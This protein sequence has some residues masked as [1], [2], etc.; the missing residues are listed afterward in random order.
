MSLA[1]KAP[2]SSLTEAC[3]DPILAEDKRKEDQ[4]I[5]TIKEKI[6]AEQLYLQPKLTL[7]ELSRHLN[8]N[9]TYLSA[10]INHQTG[11]NFNAFVNDFRLKHIASYA[12]NNPRTSAEKLAEMSGF[13]SV[14]SMHR[15]M[16][17][18]ELNQNDA[19]I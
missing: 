18:Q 2:L 17:R 5:Q 4:F 13:G 15:A 10:V 14:S 7:T 1:Q 11:M 6:L 12:K 3:N 9:R 8:T 19:V 16:K